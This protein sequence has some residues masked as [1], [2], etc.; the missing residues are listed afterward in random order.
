MAGGLLRR[1]VV[2]ADSEGEVCPFDAGQQTEQVGQS[3]TRC[4]V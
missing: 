3:G 1:R 4:G 2:S